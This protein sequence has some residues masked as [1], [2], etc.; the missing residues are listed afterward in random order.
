ML[1]G[2]K[3][4]R[5]GELCAEHEISQDQ[6]YEWRDQ[7]LANAAKAFE[8]AGGPQRQSRLQRE[9]ARLKV[10]VGELTLEFQRKARRSWGE[11]WPLRQ[12]G[13]AQRPR[14][15]SDP[16][17]Q[18]P[19]PDLGLPPDL[20][21]SA[22]RRWPRS[23][24]EARLQSRARPGCGTLEPAQRPDQ[25]A[26]DRLALLVGQDLDEGEPGRASSTATCTN[27]QPTLLFRARRSPGQRGPVPSRRR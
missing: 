27:S 7:F 23:Q 12:G 17:L 11:A 16:G 19:A 21:A 2:L 14:C 1:E 8:P 20:G 25:E 9:N 10:L 3:G 15:S 24:R 22:L 26:G 6:Y 4:R 13:D 5:I 18:G